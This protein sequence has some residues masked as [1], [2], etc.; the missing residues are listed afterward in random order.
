MAVQEIAHFEAARN[1]AA[2]RWNGRTDSAGDWPRP[3]P[4]LRSCRP[5]TRIAVRAARD[6]TTLELNAT[7]CSRGVHRGRTRQ[8]LREPL[9]RWEALAVR[10]RESEPSFNSRFSNCSFDRNPL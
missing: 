10:F 8:L 4:L 3:A 1:G 7:Q 6:G 9:S 2:T 5:T